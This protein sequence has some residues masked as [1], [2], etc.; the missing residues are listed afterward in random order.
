MWSNKSLEDV[1]AA[2]PRE[3]PLM[4]QLNWTRDRTMTESVVR[5]AETAGYRAIVVTADQPIIGNMPAF[6]R[7]EQAYLNKTSKQTILSLDLT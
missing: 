7:H 6:E 1:A 4:M 5:R 2:V 3:T